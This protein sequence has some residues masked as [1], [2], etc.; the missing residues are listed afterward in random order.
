MSLRSCRAGSDTSA[1]GVLF[2]PANGDSPDELVLDISS[3]DVLSTV[4]RFHTFEELCLKFLACGNRKSLSLVFHFQQT[5]ALANHL[6]GRSIPA[7]LHFAGAEAFEFF[8]KGK[9]IWNGG[10]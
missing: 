2:F 5:Q 1:S 7:T 10:A 9:M 3:W 4:Q 8:G 6:A